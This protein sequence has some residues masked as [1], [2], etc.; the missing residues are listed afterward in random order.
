MCSLV[1]VSEGTSHYNHALCSYALSPR[2]HFQ[3]T[4]Y[5]AL[6]EYGQKTFLSDHHTSELVR[7]STLIR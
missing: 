6:E 4:S 5:V 1:C 2:R 7:S 3:D